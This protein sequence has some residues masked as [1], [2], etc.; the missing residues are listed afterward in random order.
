M[1][2]NLYLSLIN[3]LFFLHIFLKISSLQHVHGNTELKALMEVKAS[4]DPD[5]KILDGDPCSGTFEGVACNEHNEVA[6]ISLQ[7]KGL[8]GKLSPAVSELNCL[9]DLFLHFNSLSGEI[10][11]EI[12]YLTEFVDLYLNP[13]ELQTLAKHNVL[14]LQYSIEWYH[15]KKFRELVFTKMAGFELQSPIW[16]DPCKLS[17]IPQL[18]F[19]HL[20][21]N[22]LLGIVSSS[23]KKLNEGF[24]CGNNSD[25]CGVGFISLRACAAW[26]MPNV[27]RPDQS[28][29]SKI[30]ATAPLANA[31]A[32][33]ITRHCNRTN[34]S[35]S[36]KILRVGIVAEVQHL[37]Q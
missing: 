13:Q 25:A 2:K 15:S 31:E 36:S 9:S 16:F 19:L 3:F 22:S 7:G 37:S 18:E 12:S 11:K 1:N 29:I 20:Q 10:P 30:N 4:L 6:N 8:S 28:N 34:C 24:Q 33:N 17:E 14:G 32:A 35:K 21:D 5:N 23:L 26:D 27:N